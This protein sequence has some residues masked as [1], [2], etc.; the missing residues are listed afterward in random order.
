MCIKLESVRFG[1]D[2]QGATGLLVIDKAEAQWP[3]A[4]F[5]FIDYN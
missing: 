4:F 1:A 5:E 2:H 3:Q